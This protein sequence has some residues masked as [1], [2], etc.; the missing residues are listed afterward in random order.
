MNENRIKLTPSSLKT[1]LK[2][3]LKR[4]VKLNSSNILNRVLK[5]KI[6]PSNV[7]QANNYLFIISL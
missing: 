6:N 4:E 1:P 7:Y 5:A 2:T 3:L